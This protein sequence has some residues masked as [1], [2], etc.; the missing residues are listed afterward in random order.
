MAAHAIRRLTTKAST[1]QALAGTAPHHNIYVFLH[2]PRSPES[3][4]SVIS[5]PLQKALQLQLAPLHGLVNFSWTSRPQPT[6]LNSEWLEEDSYSATV[7]PMNGRPFEIEQIS[8]SN[9]VQVVEKI[10]TQSQPQSL[11]PSDPIRIYVCT[12]GARD[13]RCGETGGQVANAL[14]AEIELRNLSEAV[15]LGETAHVGGHKC[16][17]CKAYDT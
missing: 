12:H 10:N 4:P 6:Q 17:F 5:S 2:S 9:L 15:K 13:C 3:F 8:S 16:V 14:R 1:S 7:F 11:T